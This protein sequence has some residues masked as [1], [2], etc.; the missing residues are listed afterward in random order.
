MLLRDSDDLLV[1]SLPVDLKSISGIE[2]F[3]GSQGF[4][5]SEDLYRVPTV[6]SREYRIPNIGSCKH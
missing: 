1:L 3:L 2:A 5:G 6:R 4:K